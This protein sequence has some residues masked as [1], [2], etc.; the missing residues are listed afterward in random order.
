MLTLPFIIK[1][2]NCTK[3]SNEYIPTG[4]NQKYCKTCKAEIRLKYAKEY[5][6]KYVKKSPKSEID[7]TI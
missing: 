5:S 4:A 1:I 6:K 2:K 7:T 3:C